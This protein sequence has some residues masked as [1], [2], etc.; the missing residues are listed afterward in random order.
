MGGYLPDALK[1]PG[2]TPDKQATLMLT[3]EEATKRR[4]G[5]FTR[6][7]DALGLFDVRKPRP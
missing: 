2:S 1:V 5:A 3:S 6:V 7:E 4:K